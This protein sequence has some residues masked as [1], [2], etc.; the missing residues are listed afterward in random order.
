MNHLDM[1]ASLRRHCS[2]AELKKNN[3]LCGVHTPWVFVGHPGLRTWG[4]LVNQIQIGIFVINKSVSVNQSV[5][6][7]MNKHFLMSSNFETEVYVIKKHSKLCQLLQSIH[8]SSSQLLS[9]TWYFFRHN[10]YIMAVYLAFYLTLI[11]SLSL[12]LPILFSVS[13][14]I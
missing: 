7:Y 9:S 8:F 13:V 12:S 3:I 14:K 5:K 2:L 10:S 1:K 6:K 4:M 11:I